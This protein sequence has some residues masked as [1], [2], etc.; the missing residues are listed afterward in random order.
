MRS[1]REYVRAI[2]IGAVAVVLLAASAAAYAQWFL[3]ERQLTTS[4]ASPEWPAISG[5]KVVY[6]DYRGTRLE[7][8]R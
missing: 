1:Q 3:P 5:T 2:L 6:S 7:L 8:P 4:A